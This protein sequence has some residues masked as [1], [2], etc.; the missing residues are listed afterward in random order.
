[1]D[2]GAPCTFDRVALQWIRRPAEAALQISDDAATW[3]TVEAL[4]AAAD[5]KLA[6]PAKARYVRVLL[7]KPASSEGYILSELEVYGRGGPV[8]QP[9]PASGLS[10]G[11]W[12]IERDSLVTA[13]GETLSKPGFQDKDWLVATVPATVLSSYWNA[14]ALPDPIMATTSSRFRIRS[15][16]PISGI[17]TSSPRRRLLPDGAPG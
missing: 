13:N 10:G 9:K 8:P 17:A 3:K 2:L 11:A 5:F 6:R 1:V 15:S 4:P 16:T 14:G 7:T 12:R